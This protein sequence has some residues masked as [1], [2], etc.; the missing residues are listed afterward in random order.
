MLDTRLQK[1]MDSEEG[2][3]NTSFWDIHPL[4]LMIYNGEVE[5]LKAEIHISLDKIPAGRI[6]RDER[7][8]SE[9]LTVCL[10][11]AFMIAAI[12]GG[13]YPPEANAIADQALYRLSLIRSVSDIPDI[14]RKEAVT[15]CE[16]VRET[17]RTDTGN[18][19]VEKAKHYMST[20]LTQTIQ[21]VDV[22]QAVGLSQFHLSRLFKASTG[23]T[24][25]KYLIQKR[26][27]TAKHLLLTSDRTIPQIAFLLRFCDQ[28]Y[29]TQVFR[30]ETG[31]TPG[32]FRCENRID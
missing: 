14:V 21:M 26:I 3:L 2:Y 16:M 30:K 23:M 20:H 13:V 1:L 19:H 24:M 32:Q 27:E 4:F 7:K 10:V 8:Q 18:I 15:L 22:A 5:R 12:Y 29:F 11:T 31:L 6:T 28:S 25:Q 9:Y 17:K